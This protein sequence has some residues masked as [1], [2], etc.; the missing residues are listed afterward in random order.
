MSDLIES[1]NQ[2]SDLRG[3]HQ[4]EFMGVP[5][6]GREVEMTGIVPERVGGGKVTESWVDRD[7]PGLMQQL[8]VLPVP[9]PA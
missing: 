7:S 5:P 4:G 9:V 3:T 2:A 6:T 8:G 1:V